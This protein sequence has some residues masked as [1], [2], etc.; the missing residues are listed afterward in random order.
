MSDL[1]SLYLLLNIIFPHRNSKILPRWSLIP[2]QAID[3]VYDKEYPNLG[4]ENVAATQTS[5]LGLAQPQWFP[6]GTSETEFHVFGIVQPRKY[7]RYTRAFEGEDTQQSKETEVD[8]RDHISTDLLP[9]F[10][11]TLV[12]EGTPIVQVLR[13]ICHPN[14]YQT[15]R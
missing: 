5:S 14:L 2:D 11:D 15:C 6:T 12:L 1:W 7:K 9:A 4:N 13:A 8:K 10:W 3:H